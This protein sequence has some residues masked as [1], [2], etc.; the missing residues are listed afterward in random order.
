MTDSADPEGLRVFYYLV[1]D[2][3]AL[4]FS[5]ISLHFKVILTSL[6]SVSKSLIPFAR[7]SPFEPNAPSMRTSTRTSHPAPPQGREKKRDHCQGEGCAQNTSTG[8]TTQREGRIEQTPTRS[9][10]RHRPQAVKTWA[11]APR[12]GDAPAKT[13]QLRWTSGPGVRLGPA[14]RAADWLAAQQRIESTAPV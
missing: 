6:S 1:Q 4:V 10:S 3:K 14:L 13:P 11:F 12:V 9:M 8:W 2:L 7:S 5:L